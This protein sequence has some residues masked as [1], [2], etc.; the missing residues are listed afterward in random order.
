M[1]DLKAEHIPRTVTWCG[2]Q[3]CHEAGVLSQES[4][5][6]LEKTNQGKCIYSSL[7]F[8]HKCE[9]QAS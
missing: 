7:M 1:E 3:R 2:S 6:S 8:K 4:D 5:T 9:K